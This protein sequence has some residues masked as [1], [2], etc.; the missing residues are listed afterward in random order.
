M[1]CPKIT[2]RYQQEV[3]NVP[4]LF[5]IG[6][7]EKK[8]GRAETYVK[9]T[10]YRF[11]AKEVD[12]ETGLHYYGAR[13]YNSN[14]S[15]WLSVDPIL[16]HHESP[17]AAFSNN[18][19]MLI[20]PDG[21]DTSFADNQA[22]NDFESALNTVNSKVSHYQQR[23]NENKA[24]AN[25]KGFGAAVKRFFRNEKA[26]AQNLANWQKLESDFDNIT[27]PNTAMVE[28]SSSTAPLGANEN[29]LTQPQ[30]NGDV[31]VN[32]RAGHISAYIH[33]NRH[34]NQWFSRTSG[35]VR[36]TDLFDEIQAFQYQ[37][38]F[39]PS[40]VQNLIIRGAQAQHGA[41]WQSIRP[42]YG[43][44]DLVKYLYPGIIQSTTDVK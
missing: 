33:E 11:N 27:D 22:R 20:D 39:D 43:L 31:K 36:N 3:I 38:I 28:Y 24:L 18:P 10:P 16:K 34:V 7:V 37:A 41:N 5:V 9:N 44:T 23:V 15:I 19:I 26:D 8:E 6:P 4:P 29:G 30:T 13:Y 21:R 40:G 2:Y 35:L 32:I 25:Q 1:G 14:L 12:P 17:Y 42:N